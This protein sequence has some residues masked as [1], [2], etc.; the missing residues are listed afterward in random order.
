MTIEV[1]HKKVSAIADSGDTDIVQPSDWNDTHEIQLATARLIGRTTAGAGAAEEIS[2]GAGLSLSGLSI[3]FDATWGDSRYVQP[4][5]VGTAA[6]EDVTTSPTDTTD[7]RLT[8]VGDFGLGRNSSTLLPNPDADSL[9]QIGGLFRVDATISNHPLSTLGGALF[10]TCVSGAPNNGAHRIWIYRNNNN[11]NG[12]RVFA[13]TTNI[14]NTAFIAAQELYH[15][16]VILGTVSQSAGVPTGAVIERG[17]NANGEY[18]KFADGTMI[19]TR[20]VTFQALSSPHVW[21]HPSSFASGA[22]VIAFLTTERSDNSVLQQYNV[23][24]TAST[25]SFYL[26]NAASQFIWRFCAIG[27]WF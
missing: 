5:D 6:Y 12:L 20:Y 11:P 7:G 19:C 1:K 27:R 23:V 9:S 24:T 13:Q 15:R 22:S 10:Q 4:A 16:G 2:A 8:K 3:S 14:T 25:S 17:S 26:S 18:V 21:T